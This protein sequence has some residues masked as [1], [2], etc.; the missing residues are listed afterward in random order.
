MKERLPGRE[1]APR[2]RDNTYMHSAEQLTNA[3]EFHYP[4]TVPFEA[5]NED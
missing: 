3:G 5:G 4:F 2:V 1:A